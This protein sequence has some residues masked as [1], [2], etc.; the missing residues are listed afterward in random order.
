MSIMVRL[1]FAILF[2]VSSP[3]QG[4]W[5]QS[6]PGTD[7]STDVAMRRRIDSVFARAPVGDSADWHRA[8]SLLR[9][10]PRRALSTAMAQGDHRLLAYG[11]VA[12]VAPG[13][14]PLPERCQ[15][16]AY[17][18][19]LRQLDNTGDVGSTRGELWLKYAAQRL[20]ERYNPLLIERL[21]VCRQ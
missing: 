12:L 21:G 9:V 18:L 13:L 19:G 5:G 20:A 11:S 14:D 1:T 2:L 4:V 16:A 17:R 7:S 8:D 6:R 3:M 15:R 10:D